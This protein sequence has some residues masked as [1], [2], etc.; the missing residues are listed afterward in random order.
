MVLTEAVG[1]KVNADATDAYQ[2]LGNELHG[3]DARL[4][5]IVEAYEE[6]PNIIDSG[7]LSVTDRTR[8]VEVMVTAVYRTMRSLVYAEDSPL[9]ADRD[10]WDAFKEQRSE[11]I[12]FY[13]SALRELET[14]KEVLMAYR[15]MKDDF[16][17]RPQCGDLEQLRQDTQTLVEARESCIEAISN[18]HGK[19]S[20]M[21]T[22]L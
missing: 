3:I 6:M 16:R 22:V 19:F 13:R 12:F 15:Q 1:S 10:V 9:R 18:F 4:R 2:K 11:F 21:L 5:T 14:Y 8:G 7:E 20:A 17:P